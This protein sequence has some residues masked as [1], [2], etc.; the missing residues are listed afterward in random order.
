GFLLSHVQTGLHPGHL[1]T[2]TSTIPYAYHNTAMLQLV[3]TP[4]EIFRHSLKLTMTLAVTITLFSL[5]LGISTWLYVRQKKFFLD[6]QDSEK[7]YR[8][9]V[10]DAQD[11]HYRTDLEGNVVF[12][13]RAVTRLSGYSVEEIIGQ[14]MNS[15]YVNPEERDTFLATLKKNGF[16]REFVARLKRKDNSTWWASTNAHFYYDSAGS[17]LGVE[18]IA[19]DVSDRVTAELALQ[20]REAKL[21]SILQ[22]SPTGIGVVAERVFQE[23]NQRFCEMVGYTE[24]ELLGKNS[25]MVYLSIEEHERVGQEQMENLRHQGV[26]TIESSLRHKSGRMINILV[27]WTL[28]YHDNPAA[29]IVFNVLD[30]T[31][32]K[33]I[34]GELLASEKRYQTILESMNDL[35]YICSDSYRMEYLNPAMVRKIGYDAT[36]ES[37]FSV[38]NGFEAPCPWCHRIADD[39][40]FLP[41]QE[42]T[43]PVDNHC[44]HVSHSPIINAD[45]S[46][47][48]LIMLRDISGI[49]KLE[50]QLQQS[51]KLEAIGTLAGGVAHDFNNIL[52][53]IHGYAELA[54]MNV[55]QGSKVWEEIRGIE[56]AG[57]RAANLTRQLLAFSRKQTI[58]PQKIN[59][60]RLLGDL[61]KMLQRLISEDISLTLQMA[62]NVGFI[63]ADPGQVEQLLVNLV[64]NARDAVKA[65]GAREKVIIIGTSQIFLDSTFVA[66]HHGSSNGWHVQIK[67]SDK[68]CGMSREVQE[69]IFE[70]FYTTKEQGQG[71]GLGLATVYGIVK[72]NK[73]SVHIVSEPGHGTVVEIYWPVMSDIM[74]DEERETPAELPSGGSETILLVEDDEEI[75]KVISLQ[76]RQA[77]YLVVEAA[78]GAQALAAAETHQGAIDLLFTD[79]VMPV[80]GGLELSQKIL[81][82]YPQIAILFASGYVDT[83]IDENFLKLYRN[84]LISKPYTITEVMDRIR[85]LLDVHRP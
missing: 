85:R 37:C 70:P 32:Q 82:R 18:G 44:Y 79:V 67:V 76:L 71:T 69:H 75:R 72:Q 4:D 83:T 39:H 73:G 56:K 50:H 33:K 52:T 14:Q 66:S 81:T 51:Q 45:G 21:E 35:V 23:V 1:F 80:M 15:V 3:V 26:A 43:C 58:L 61:Y 65:H 9:L 12:I 8:S 11:I 30:I 10:D 46:H 41:E 84:Q 78:N 64:I 16:V 38:L 13:S 36:G 53:A 2:L 6:L 27:S 55:E 34:G 5:F 68:G 7:K 29:G 24:Q 60:N 25:A 42:F 17:I 57:N 77:G 49:K 40:G 54:L 31:E 22:A 47:S 28:L 20:E 19:R 74:D 59:I 48:N 62:D 63:Y